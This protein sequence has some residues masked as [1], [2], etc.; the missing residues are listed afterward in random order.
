MSKRFDEFFDR[1]VLN[2]VCDFFF[3]AYFGGKS[4]HLLHIR[5]KLNKWTIKNF[6]TFISNSVIWIDTVNYVLDA[7]LVQKFRFACEMSHLNFYI[8]SILRV[9]YISEMLRDFFPS[10]LKCKNDL[11]KT[12]LVSERNFDILNVIPWPI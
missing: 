6:E 7:Y 8:S 5:K 11:T 1:L 3:S 10:L 2:S 12:W 4:C 9:F